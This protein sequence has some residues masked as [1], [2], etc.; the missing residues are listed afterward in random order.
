ME[1]SLFMDRYPILELSLNKNE[2]KFTTISEVIDYF[3]QQIEAHPIAAYI[4]EFDHFAHTQRIG[5][6]IAP[7]MLAAQH[8]IC[9]FG[10]KLPNPQVMAVRPR[11]IGVV[12]YADKFVITFLEPPMPTATEAMTKWVSGLRA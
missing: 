2:A 4:G 11:S 5:G 1:Q 7:D 6:E 8:I 9:C 12:E 10:T 3:K